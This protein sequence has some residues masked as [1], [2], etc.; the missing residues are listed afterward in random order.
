MNRTDRLAEVLF[1]TG[2][3]T[4]GAGFL[5]IVALLVAVLLAVAWWLPEPPS[6]QLLVGGLLVVSL[7]AVVFGYWAHR[8]YTFALAEQGHQARRAAQLRLSIIEALA[9]AIDAR[10][11]TTHSIRR[12]QAYAGALASSLGLSEAEIEAV[13]TAALLHDIGKLAVPD[14]ILTK[15]GPLT[16][17]ERLKVRT[18][19]QVGADIIAGVPFPYAVGP[20]VLCHH[21]HWD[22]SGYPNGLKGHD[23]PIGARVLAVADYFEALTSERPFHPPMPYDEAVKV[24]WQE[25]GK[26]LDPAIVTRFVELLPGLVLAEA[27]SSGITAHAAPSGRNPLHDIGRAHREIHG[28]YEVARGMGTALGV[29]GSMEVM[30]AG[31]QSL[32]AFSDCALFLWDRETQTARCR[33][34]RGL[35]A[36]AIEALSF[37]TG[38]GAIG[39]AIANDAPVIAA[40]AAS[41]VPGCAILGTPPPLSMLA[42][43]LGTGDGTIGAI[44]LYADRRD[45]FGQDAV[46]ITKEIAAQ[47]AA[48]LA[49]A[50]TF[51][52]AQEESITDPLTGL[53]NTRFMHAH[54]NRELARAGR[55]NSSVSLLLIDCDGLK[56]V[57]DSHGHQVGD[58]VLCE[59]ADILRNAIRPYDACA[60]YGGDEFI[61]ALADCGLREAEAKGGELQQA[62]EAHPLVTPRGSRIRCSISFGAASCPGDG[63]TYATLLASADSRMYADKENRRHAGGGARGRHQRT[64]AL[65]EADIQ[66][67]AAGVL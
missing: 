65:S 5:L 37:H 33:W 58:Q 38:Q 47:A 44:A 4:G 30:A 41:E 8:R 32:V 11:R 35:R 42:Y 6:S 29:S 17:D 48:V 64:G 50:L 2:E 45:A 14:H 27:G 34:S 66:Q 18:H 26:A 43:P 54:L 1:G 53:P 49:N 40:D 23:I 9:L 60:R 10:D 12:E 61:V 21:E 31:L 19:P 39:R 59:I 25:A 3:R 57:N 16:P 63:S 7:V 15:P 22:G 13:R 55:Q 24:L 62:V 56:A 52:Q 28:L 46:R 67:A 20:L 36:T 51:E